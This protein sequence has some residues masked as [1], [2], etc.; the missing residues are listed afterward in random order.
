MTKTTLL[1]PCLLLA[2]AACN[3]DRA[4]PTPS[5]DAP[6]ADAST[7][8]PGTGATPDGAAPGLPEAP[9]ASGDA[10]F[11]GYGPLRFGM[12]E[13][14]ARAAW[15]GDLRNDFAGEVCHYLQPDT[16]KPPAY[17]AF[18]FENGR[19][20]RYDVGNPDE[21]APGGGRIGMSEEEIQARYPGRV[22]VRPHHY[23]EGGHYLRVPAEQGDGLLVFET[24]A[25]GRVTSWRGG[26]APQV[27]Y[28]EGCA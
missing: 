7:A 1:L 5:A 15:D 26:V 13:A 17:F 28:I 22:E 4:P 9:P 2:L 11:D 19:F 16:G 23:V 18:M 24:D 25:E 12:D 6:A 14:Q 8:D 21:V 20:V 10:R 27:D 3:A